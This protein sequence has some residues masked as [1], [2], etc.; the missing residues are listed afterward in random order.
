MV[1]NLFQH[2]KVSVDRGID[3]AIREIIGMHALPRSAFFDSQSGTDQI[4]AVAGPLL[5]CHQV[6]LAQDK[7][8][9]LAICSCDASGIRITMYRLSSY[10]STF[11]R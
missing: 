9:L 4:E 11:A 5:K 8:E 10:G 6:I 3:Q 2:G 7:A 1:A